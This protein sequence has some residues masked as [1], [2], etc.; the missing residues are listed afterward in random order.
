MPITVPLAIS[1]YLPCTLW[2]LQPQGVP[3]IPK[4]GSP[5]PHLPVFS[6]KSFCLANCS[7]FRASSDMTSEML[8]SYLDVAGSSSVLPNTSR[9]PRLLVSG[10]ICL[11]DSTGNSWGSSDV[12]STQRSASHVVGGEGMLLC[13]LQSP[14]NPQNSSRGFVT[15]FHPLSH[16]LHSCP[17]LWRCCSE[18]L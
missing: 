2:E 8:F 17:S 15:F 12:L 3:H 9:S 16:F 6:L 10:Y 11:L 5:L 13:S 7:F 4:H 14:C 18:W 1:A